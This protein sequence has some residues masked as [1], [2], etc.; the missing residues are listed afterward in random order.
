MKR[1]SLL[2]FFYFCAAF[3]VTSL[4]TQ[5]VTGGLLK[6]LALGS[7]FLGQIGS[8]HQLHKVGAV[9]HDVYGLSLQLDQEG[10]PFISYLEKNSFEVSFCQT[11]T[12]TKNIMYGMSFRSYDW[13]PCNY[14]NPFNN[15]TYTS[16][17]IEN[18]L[19]LDAIALK[20]SLHNNLTKLFSIET[21]GNRGLYPSL[22][23][24]KQGNPVI[25]YGDLDKELLRLV[26]CESPYC[27]T[28]NISTID[29]INVIS[30][31]PAL[32]LSKEDHPALSYFSFEERKAKIAICD[33][34]SCMDGHS[35]YTIDTNGSIG[36]YSSFQFT[37]D[38]NPVVAFYDFVSGDLNLIICGDP[39]CSVYTIVKIDSPGNIGQDMLYPS[40][41]L[42][43]DDHPVIAYFDHYH[44][45][46]K[47]AVCTDPTC[48]DTIRM[49]TVMWEGSVGW[50]PALQLKKNGL[51]VIVYY[52]KTNRYIALV[53][54]K[55]AFCT[56]DDAFRHF[57][58]IVPKKLVVVIGI[59]T[60][61]LI[62][63]CILIGLFKV[64]DEHDTSEAVGGLIASEEELERPDKSLYSSENFK[65]LYLISV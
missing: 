62:A 64:P 2:S 29:T 58:S 7:L 57:L 38:N 1:K 40:L 12:C 45:D 49:N 6:T 16:F 28:Y 32:Q 24:N 8:S 27:T 15:R 44:E 53:T 60:A 30:S 14:F 54:C 55:D 46:L 20:S 52:D 59:T 41:Q 43:E 10:D 4:A 61:F 36:M 50:T 17:F 3:H 56:N 34:P 63:I 22:Q 18:E 39:T 11:P 31:H 26:V 19:L 5:A 23:S 42:N 48:M 21:L 47:I 37:K 35:I 13:S 33:D 25:S 51:P 65:P 9:D